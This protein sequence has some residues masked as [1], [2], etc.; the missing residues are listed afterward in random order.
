M[1]RTLFCHNF[2]AKGVQLTGY[3]TRI[4]VRPTSRVTMEPRIVS[5]GRLT[6]IVGREGNLQIGSRVYFNEYTIISCIES[7][8]IGKNCKFG[9][10]VC[11]YDSNHQYDAKDG[12]KAV[13]TTAPIRIGEGCWIGANTIILKGSE[14]GD[15]CVIG[16]GCIISGRIPAHSIVTS[17]RKLTVR[18]I[19][20]HE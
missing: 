16:A 1:L 14:I 2:V 6:I 15:N 3:N 19:K 7:V 18:P 4:C 11:I 10:H 5:D 12:V 17:D 13:S 8:T 20:E 9:P